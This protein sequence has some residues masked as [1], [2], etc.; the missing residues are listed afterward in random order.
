MFK[1]VFLPFG[2]DKTALLCTGSGYSVTSQQTVC[3]GCSDLRNASKVCWFS[4]AT[5]Q[6]Q[7]YCSNLEMAHLKVSYSHE[8]CVTPAL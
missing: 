3:T 1:C 8:N 2:H 6:F 7:K 5:L 4:S